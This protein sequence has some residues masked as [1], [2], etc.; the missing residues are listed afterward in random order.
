MVMQKKNG[1]V[2]ERVHGGQIV[3]DK[4]D[5]RETIMNFALANN[6]GSSTFF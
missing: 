3:R 5:T 6:F 2:Y 1:S 4:N